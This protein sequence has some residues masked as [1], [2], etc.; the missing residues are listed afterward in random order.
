MGRFWRRLKEF[1]SARSGDAAASGADADL[2][3][4]GQQDFNDGDVTD[5]EVEGSDGPPVVASDLE[6]GDELISDV[7]GGGDGDADEQGGPDCEDA[8]PLSVD[9]TLTPLGR[10]AAV[11]L[12]LL[13]AF[14]VVRVVGRLW[15][16]ATEPAVDA[17]AAAAAEAAVAARPLAA[18]ARP[19]LQRTVNAVLLPVV[20]VRATGRAAAYVAG[21]TLRGIAHAAVLL[22]RAFLTTGGAVISLPRLLASAWPAGNHPAAA[23][24]EA[25]SAASVWELE[26]RV[27]RLAEA[28][29]KQEAVEEAMSTAAAAKRLA[30]EAQE[31]AAEE[32]LHQ[33]VTRAVAEAEDRLR[34]SRAEAGDGMAAEAAKAAVRGLEERL[35]ALRARVSALEGAGAAGE[36]A[37]AAGEGEEQAAATEAAEAAISAAKR[38]EAAQVHAVQASHAAERASEAAS[39]RAEGVEAAVS[40]A[41]SAATDAAASAGAA[42]EAAKAVEAASAVPADA[43]VTE[44]LGRG[45]AT[46]AVNKAIERC[47]CGRPPL[48]YPRCS[49]PAARASLAA[50]ALLQVRGGQGGSRGLRRRH[51]RRSGRHRVRAL[52][53]Q[54]GERGETLGAHAPPFPLAAASPR[55]RTRASRTWCGPCWRPRASCATRGAR[56]GRSRCVVPHSGS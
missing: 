22:G 27:S 16:P 55:P 7:E 45:E 17:G 6:S 12:I 3:D 18:I 49:T 41:E 23:G 25:A 20:G 19:V 53:T 40:R 48:L 10:F 30:S 32:A 51:G 8:A 36:G 15:S 21:F 13:I 31:R 28:C 24:S 14:A 42:A 50:C 43:A 44:A 54:G 11:L 52:S 26:D 4:D 1:R 34:A 33:A 47:V 56:S 37:G 46:E 2:D 35:E 29:A 39:V 5:N 9:R 38:A